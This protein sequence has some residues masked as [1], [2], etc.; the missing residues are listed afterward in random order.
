MNPD[1]LFAASMFQSL[2]Q[3]IFTFSNFLDQSG[4]LNILILFSTIAVFI[5]TLQ[6]LRFLR[7][8]E[9]EEAQRNLTFEL[10]QNTVRL[11]DRYR[12][13]RSPLI[14]TTEYPPKYQNKNPAS[15]QP[16]DEAQIYRYV[17]F[18]RWG[19]FHS[20][21]EHLYDQILFSEIYWKP[22]CKNEIHELEL[23]VNEL[24][25][26]IEQFILFKKYELTNSPSAQ[27]QHLE[28]LHH[29]VFLQDEQDAQFLRLQKNT[30]KIVKFLQK[31]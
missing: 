7:R 29:F 6:G 27:P 8:Q 31:L 3:N 13:L 24:K 25:Y 14:Q 4:L 30:Q 28:K 16:Q 21:W 1:A 15:L 9:K 23:M 18:R 2:Q 10:M 22:W 12:A 19:R 20:E 11:R 17:F 5:L 26:H